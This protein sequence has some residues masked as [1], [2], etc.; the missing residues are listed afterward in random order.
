LRCSN[1]GFATIGKQFNT[2]NEAGIIGSKK[3]RD[4]RDLIRFGNAPQP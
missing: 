1:L 4:A 2:R 3:Q